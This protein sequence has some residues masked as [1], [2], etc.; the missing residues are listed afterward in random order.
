MEILQ[1]VS[2]NRLYTKMLRVHLFSFFPIKTSRALA[3]LVPSGF[4]I[5]QKKLT[6][7]PT[8]FINSNFSDWVFTIS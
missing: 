8:P 2:K 3:A 6:N 5:L 1:S 4:L 7:I